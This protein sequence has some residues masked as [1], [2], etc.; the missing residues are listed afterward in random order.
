MGLL[1]NCPDCGR[2]IHLTKEV[3]NQDHIAAP[4]DPWIFALH[5]ERAD[6][7]GAKLCKGSNQEVKP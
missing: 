2:G 4:G 3:W 6:V 7:M 5:Y 1:A